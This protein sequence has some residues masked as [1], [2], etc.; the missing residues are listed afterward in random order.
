MTRCAAE[1][2]SAEV[3]GE[4]VANAFRP[5]ERPARV[6]HINLPFDVMNGPAPD[7]VLTPVTVPLLGHATESA[8]VEAVRLIQAAAVP[9]LLV[10]MDPSR[11]ANAALLRALLPAYALPTDCTYQGASIVPHE[12]LDCYAGRLGLFHN[13]PSDHLLVAADLVISVGYNPIEYDPYLWKADEPISTISWGRST[14]ITGR[15][16]STL[17][18][19]PPRSQS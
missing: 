4:V 15:R 1:V 9:V 16:L 14:G 11:P 13:Q 8:I 2:E 10:G 3:I 5:V 18:I 6:G 19:S 17:A 12:P 7:D